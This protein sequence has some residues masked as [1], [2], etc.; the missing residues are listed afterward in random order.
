MPVFPWFQCKQSLQE[1]QTIQQLEDFEVSVVTRTSALSYGSV[2]VTT[3]IT[4][5]IPVEKLKG[6]K[7]YSD[8]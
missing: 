1:A 2:P 4:V 7:I 5:K 8:L 3:S 6:M